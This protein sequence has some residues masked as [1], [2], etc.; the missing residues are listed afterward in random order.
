MK[1]HKSKQQITTCN[2]LK[3]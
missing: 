3:F 2:H 1:R